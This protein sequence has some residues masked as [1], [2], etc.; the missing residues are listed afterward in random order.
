MTYE[1]CLGKNADK[2]AYFVFSVMVWVY[3][4]RLAKEVLFLT[5]YVQNL[6]LASLINTVD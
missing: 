4:S 6:S 5:I 3:F 1:L 2:M